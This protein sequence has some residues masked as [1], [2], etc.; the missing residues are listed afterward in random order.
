MRT[1]ELERELGLTK[2]AIQ[3]YEKEGFIQPKRDENGYRNYTEQDIQ[4]LQLVKFLRNLNISIDDVKAIIN[5]K[6]SFQECLKVNKIHL[7]KQIQSLT[8][9]QER[10]KNIEQKNLTLIPA[11]DNIKETVK[12]QKGLGFHKTTHTVSLGRKLTKGIVLRKWLITLILALLFNL[13]HF[14]FNLT[15][16][17]PFIARIICNLISL[18]IIQNFFIGL[19]FQLSMLLLKDVIDHT[20]NQ[21]LEFLDQ[22][23]C[24][25][26]RQ[27][28][29]N[30]LKYYY[31]VLFNHEEKHMTYYR[32]ED[33]D[34]VEIRT[35]HRYISI[36]NPIAT[37]MY[38]TDL[39]F[40]FQDGH[41][42]FFCWPMILDDDARYIGYIL[43]DKIKNIEDKDNILYAFKNV[44]N[45]ND[46]LKD[47]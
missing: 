20:M 21:S 18:F 9:V 14:Q 12:S 32:Y 6:V 25:Y 29:I 38:V 13:F 42:F 24:Y 36:A 46:Y 15:L 5:G 2:H 40:Y 33:I 1:K 8:E 39:K 37:D 35:V 22:G 4:I 31:S 10:M 27:G 45:L 47:Q 3:Y 11:F 17:M 23:I 30:Y 34:K 41:S 43:E 28:F 26:Q 19:N 7:D 44:I 16:D